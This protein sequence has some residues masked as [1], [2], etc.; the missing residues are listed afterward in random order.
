[1][2]AFYAWKK[3]WWTGKK[4]YSSNTRD[5]MNGDA[6][7]TLIQMENIELFIMLKLCEQDNFP[8][9]YILQN[10]DNEIL[11]DFIDEQSKVVMIIENYLDKFQ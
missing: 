8:A 2:N 5:F 6:Y 4:L 9:L 1:D 11:E 10:S 3:T 7:E